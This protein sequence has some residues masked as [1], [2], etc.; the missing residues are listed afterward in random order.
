ME[1]YRWMKKHLVNAH[2]SMINFYININLYKHNILLQIRGAFLLGFFTRDSQF[3]NDIFPK[4]KVDGT[5]VVV[6]EEEGSEYIW[7]NE[8]NEKEAK[9]VAAQ[10]QLE[11]WAIHYVRHQLMNFI[12]N[13]MNDLADVGIPAKYHDDI[14]YEGYM[15]LMKWFLEISSS[16]YGHL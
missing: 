4:V 10:L 12:S 15:S 2:N 6:I 1:R 8:K 13:L 14:I 11:L 5:D 16:N 9:T 7:G 3:L